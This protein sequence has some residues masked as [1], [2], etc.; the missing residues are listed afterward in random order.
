LHYWPE[1]TGNAPYTTSLASGLRE[2]GMHVRVL[3]GHPHYPEWRVRH[4]YG[5]W[6]SPA[7]H[8]GV[9][10][11]RLAHYVPPRPSGVRRLLSELS[12]GARLLFERWGGADV[13]VLVSPALFASAVASLRPRRS[14]GAG[15]KQTRIVWVQD[16]YSLG[17]TETKQGGPLLERIMHAV[18]SF[19]LRRADGVAVIHDRFREHV[20]GRLGVNEH[21][22]RV[23]RNWT[24]L[25]PF[26]DL[27]ATERAA[28]RSRHGWSAHETV[29]LHAG[30][31]GVK[32]GLENV[33]EA[34]RVADEQGAPVRFVL[35]GDGA[36]RAALQAG[37]S[38]I[39]RLQFIDPVGDDDFAGVLQ[40]ADALLVNEMPGLA[41]M[42][43]PSKLTSYFA[44]GRPVI[45]ATD[46]GSVTAGEL[47]DSG[48]GVRVD[49]GDPA[50]LVAAALDLA[51]DPE[52]ARTLGEAGRKYRDEVLGGAQAIDRYA[53]W[54]AGLGRAESVAG[55][56]RA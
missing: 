21:R 40:A 43:V 50:A 48:A 27:E 26:R 55:R 36:R 44:A 37:A 30:N 16:L 15:R 33:V 2:R 47:A 1:H 22:V 53:D 11:V 29:V 3:T 45:A 34:A 13:V 17:I 42:S 24:H 6:R 14:T 25:A 38:D 52:R 10:V 8:D 41:A 7:T 28:I 32:Q 46:A 56:P 4:G 20:V 39:R 9:P 12:F 54:V 31:M 5:G 35:L 23:M 49:A 18:E 19:V 51:D